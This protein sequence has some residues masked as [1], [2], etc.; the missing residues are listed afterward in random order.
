MIGFSRSE[1]PTQDLHDS[2]VLRQCG[3]AAKHNQ[4]QDPGAAAN[5]EW[6]E[7]GEHGASGGCLMRTRKADAIYDQRPN[8]GD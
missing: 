2:V 1:R 8:A 3:D 7:N 6:K 5:Y 4:K